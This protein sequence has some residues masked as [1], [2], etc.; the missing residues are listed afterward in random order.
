MDWGFGSFG[1]FFLC[2]WSTLAKVFWNLKKNLITLSYFPQ[3]CLWIQRLWISGTPKPSDCHLISAWK[4]HLWDSIWQCESHFT[5]IPH[6]YAGKVNVNC[7]KQL[8]YLRDMTSQKDLR[9]WCG[10]QNFFLCT[11][12]SLYKFKKKCDLKTN[13]NR[14]T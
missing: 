1:G 13:K 8:Q 11:I 2:K 14:T 9:M 12:F 5:G 10:Q 6:S 4:L 3:N 7:M